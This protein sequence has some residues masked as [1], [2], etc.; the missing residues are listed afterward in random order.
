LVHHQN[1]AHEN[2]TAKVVK[3]KTVARLNFFCN[4][5]IGKYSIKIRKV[6]GKITII[7][8]QE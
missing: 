3:Y 7:N 4:E 8:I 1:Q 2:P 6:I 5:K